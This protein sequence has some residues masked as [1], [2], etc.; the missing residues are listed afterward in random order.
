MHFMIGLWRL[1]RT[2]TG[3]SDCP[4]PP[5]AKGGKGEVR[6]LGCHHRR[7][8]KAKVSVSDLQGNWPLKIRPL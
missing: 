3:L 4:P 1:I 6:V 5:L 8:K 2:E 7:E